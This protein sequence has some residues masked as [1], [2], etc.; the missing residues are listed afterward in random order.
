MTTIRWAAVLLAFA[1][2]CV[3]AVEAIDPADVAPGSS[4]VC[5]TEMDGGERLE[6]P[7]TVIGSVGPWT[8]EGEMV[9]V[10]LDDDRLRHT[11][12]IAG[13][14]GSPVY[15]GGRLVGALA[16][17]WPFAKE[18]IGGVTPF[19]RM[20]NL[21][22][23]TDTESATGSAGRPAMAGLLD[24]AREATLGETLTDWLLPDTGAPSGGLTTP[25]VMSGGW[26]PT[27]SGW[28]ATGIERLGWVSVPGGSTGSVE[29]GALQP[30]DMVAGVLVDGDAVVAAGGTVTEVRGD[31]VWAFGHPFL[32]GGDLALPMARARVVSVLPS[33][34]SSFKFFTVGPIVGSFFSDRSR[35]IWGRIG[36]P[37]PLVPMS[38]VV[39]DRQYDFRAVRHPTLSPFLVAYVVQASQAARGRLFGDQ[40]LDVEI[41]LRYHDRRPVV[42]RETV[43]SGEAPAQ[44]AALAAALTAYFEN[45]AF[46]P[47][48][49]D[50]VAV[51]LRSTER[52][53][54]AEL[55]DAVVD[56]RIVRPGD[57]L[58][59]RVRIRPHRGADVS[60]EI[61]IRVPAELPDGQLDLVVADGASWTLYDLGMRPVSPGSFDDEIDLVNSL[62]PSS[63]LVVALER[64]QLGV[65]L[66]GGHVEVPPTVAL[67]LKAGLGPALTTTSYAVVDRR[68]EELD[69]ALAG[70]ERIELEVRSEQPMT[71]PEVP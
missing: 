19:V 30:G 56:R 68:V 18:P 35:G 4:G 23:P 21:S 67:Q 39:D 10:R 13:M 12:I 20:E 17:G 48:Q 40:T 34:A 65:A 63:S 69:M 41:E 70:A 25:V 22:G 33:Q 50:G 53:R 1:A 62:L 2:P 54:A 26:Q 37:T 64:R 51:E 59:V 47:P 8:P 38:V 52:L 5:V 42:Y 28:L 24:A 58:P 49:L 7:L 3:W 60:R 61:T 55:I 43:A 9:L 36:E 11:G 46:D 71:R 29:S 45:S 27:G 15:V 31:Q 16:F 57:E 14:S 44:A 6:I 32:G 66:N